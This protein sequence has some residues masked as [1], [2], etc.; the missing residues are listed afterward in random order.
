[1]TCTRNAV[2]CKKCDTVIESKWDHDFKIAGEIR[3]TAS[4]REA[5]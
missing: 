5:V 4:T 3:P 2:R 1:M